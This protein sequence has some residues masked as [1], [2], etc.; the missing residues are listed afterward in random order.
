MELLLSE[1]RATAAKLADSCSSDFDDAFVAELIEKIDE[2]A[3]KVDQAALFSK[4]E[5]VDDVQTSSLKYLMLDYFKGKAHLHFKAER[6]AHL[7][8]ARNIFQQFLDMLIN[9]YIYTEGEMSEMTGGG[10]DRGR[11]PPTADAKRTTKIANY[12]RQKAAKERLT[13][14]EHILAHAGQGVDCEDDMRE[15]VLNEIRCNT[16]DVIEEMA[17]TD[18]E[19]SMIELSQS[20]QSAAPPMAMSMPG[21][22]HNHS[23]NNNNNHRE[24]SRKGIEVTRLSKGG[25]NGEE[26]LMTRDTFKASVFHMEQLQSIESYGEQLMQEMRENEARKAGEEEEG[27]EDFGPR[28]YKK[29]H[30]DGDE[31]DLALADEAAKADREWDRWKEDNPR[32]WGNKANKRF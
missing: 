32:G 2:C 31:D 20:H 17:M 10:G 1:I 25:I 3:V 29:L 26:I 11:P 4:N 6:K 16:I 5:E 18:T 15:L 23:S 9:Y 21:S 27:A 8:S 30:E 12:K 22:H 19:L 14:L 24:E 28:R 7:L 13:E